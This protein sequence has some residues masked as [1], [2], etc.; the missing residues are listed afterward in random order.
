MIK[1]INLEV[2]DICN[3]RCKMCDIWKNKIPNYLSEEN[4]ENIFSSKFID[5]NT[6]I[7]LT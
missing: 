3:L 5:K 7:S 2:I 4:L 6:D 1:A